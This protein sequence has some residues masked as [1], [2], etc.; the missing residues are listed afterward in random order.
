[1]LMFRRISE[2][3]EACVYHGKVKEEL[4]HILAC[5]A[6]VTCEIIMMLK[7]K[8]ELTMNGSLVSSDPYAGGVCLGFMSM[9]L[10]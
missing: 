8:Y 9:Y 4:F 2:A 3:I 1:M 10:L 5:H 7:C 6:L